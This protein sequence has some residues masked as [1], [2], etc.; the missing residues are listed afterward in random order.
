[1]EITELQEKI[2]NDADFRTQL[3]SVLEPTLPQVLQEKGFVV[4]TKDD[5]ESY[6]RNYEANYLTPKVEQL[7]KEK[8]GEEVKRIHNQYD[9]DLFNLTGQRKQANQKT[10]EFMKEVWGS[11]LDETTKVFKTQVEQLS[12]EREKLLSENEQLK[13]DYT[14]KI[15][16]FKVNSVLDTD[17]STRQVALPASI[18]N[19]EDKI[20]FAKT[21]QEFVKSA[22]LQKYKYADTENGIVFL[23]QDGTPVLNPKTAMPATAADIIAMDFG[24]YFVE[25]TKTGG[26][27]SGNGQNGS[28][29]LT[30]GDM[31]LLT[32]KNIS[33][34]ATKQLQFA[35]YATSKGLTLGS[36][37]Y[38][39]AYKA[40]FY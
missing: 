26:L 39:Q 36:K 13:Q 28:S 14:H 10:Y 27:G 38:N 8:I 37:E 5:D 16:S 1:M 30:K 35:T 11:R 3:I 40:V 33:D 20:R 9:E 25:S 15:S 22:L 18:T 6:L 32:I 34:T 24:L 21:Q 23:K 31:E 29:T 12:A 17:L 7:Y 19:E 4:R 2:Q